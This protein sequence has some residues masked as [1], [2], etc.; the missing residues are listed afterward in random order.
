MRK[1]TLHG[2]GKH[3]QQVNRN[4][5]G[6]RSHNTVQLTPLFLAS[7]FL[8]GLCPECLYNQVSKSLLA[9]AVMTRRS[10]EAHV[11]LFQMSDHQEGILVYNRYDLTSPWKDI[12]GHH[13]GGKLAYCLI[14]CDTPIYIT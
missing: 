8:L 2:Q 9:T 4:K 3:V 10:S 5:H 12:F 7:K 6:C 11:L 14:Q 1:S 13:V